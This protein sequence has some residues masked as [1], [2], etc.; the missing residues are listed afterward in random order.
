MLQ[1]VLVLSCLAAA[2]GVDRGAVLEEPDPIR[3][4]PEFFGVD[5]ENAAFSSQQRSDI[6]SN[7]HESVCAHGDCNIASG[8]CECHDGWLAHKQGAAPVHKFTIPAEE[9]DYEQDKVDGYV[10]LLLAC[11]TNILACYCRV[12]DVC[13]AT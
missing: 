4:C 8:D 12:E 1:V 6:H 7:I 11:W 9:F 3:R 2:K 10:L 13:V 5:E